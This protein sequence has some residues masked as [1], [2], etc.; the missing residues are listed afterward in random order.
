MY[1]ATVID[2]ATRRLIGGSIN[3]HMR[4]GLIIDALAAAVAARGG[5]VDDV[6]FHSDRGAQGGFQWSSQHPDRGVCDGKTCGLDDDGDGQAG[7][8]V[9]GSARG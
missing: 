3:T 6:I 5:R 8:A 7:D 1:L 9:A 2:I 4:G